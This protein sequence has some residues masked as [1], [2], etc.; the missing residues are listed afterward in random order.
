VS[1]PII[2]KHFAYQQLIQTNYRDRD[3][4]PGALADAIAACQNQ[5]AIAPQVAEAMRKEYRGQP[6]PRHVGYDQLVVI[7]GKQGDYA[8]AIRLC[9][10]ARGRGWRGEWDKRIAKYS[11]Q[12]ER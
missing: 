3:S 4:R 8:E 12:L 1:R 7:R 11:K 10:E 2:D 5:I 6:L 9:A